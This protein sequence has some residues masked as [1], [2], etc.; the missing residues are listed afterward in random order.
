MTP[1]FSQQMN[2]KNLKLVIAKKAVVI[3]EEFNM[4]EYELDRV[5]IYMIVDEEA[6]RMRLMAGVVQEDSLDKDDL[7]KVLQANYDRALDA[8]YAIAN[9][10]LWS[11]FTHPLKE[12]SADQVVDALYQVRNL[13]H[14]YGTSYNSTDLV[15]GGN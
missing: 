11:V 2:F 12:I 3:K 9:N 4:V 14:N 13:V 8:K 5:R 1:A 15:F 6:N 7:K 10:I